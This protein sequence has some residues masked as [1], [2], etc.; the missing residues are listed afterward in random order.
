MLFNMQSQFAKILRVYYGSR[1]ITDFNKE[2]QDLLVILRKGSVRVS[3]STSLK[4]TL[5]HLIIETFDLGWSILRYS[6]VV[7]SGGE[8]KLVT[9]Q[10]SGSRAKEHS[11]K[12]RALNSKHGSPAQIMQTF[13]KFSTIFLSIHLFKLVPLQSMSSFEGV[14]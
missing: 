13:K 6:K 10:S 7:Q 14:H 8:Q 12:A 11:G 4:T 1:G 2:L 5:I 9:A 3:K